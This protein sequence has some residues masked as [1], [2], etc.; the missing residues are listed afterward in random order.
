MKRPLNEKEW[1]QLLKA[2]VYISLLAC[3]H[4]G[5]LLKKE[6]KGAINLAHLRTYC[7]PKDLLEYYR[8]AEVNFK[9]YLEKYDD[10][11]PEN[12]E[13]RKLILKEKLSDLIK[14]SKNLYPYYR[15][16]LILSLE[17]FGK[18]MAHVNDNFLQEMFIPILMDHLNADVDKNIIKL[19][20]D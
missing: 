4:D 16:K 1:N 2:P 10:S 14:I 17:S 13:E 11:L 3:R 7:A 6:K 19:E 18:H 9:E 15:A 5:K 8:D 20:N 12:Y